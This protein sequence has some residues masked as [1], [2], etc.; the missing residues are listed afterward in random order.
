MGRFFSDLEDF[1]F[2]KPTSFLKKSSIFYFAFGHFLWFGHLRLEF[3]AEF[4]IKVEP[5]IDSEASVQFFF[6][7][8]NFKDL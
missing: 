4:Y 1:Y 7:I 3:R 8:S 5:R 6:E 2:P